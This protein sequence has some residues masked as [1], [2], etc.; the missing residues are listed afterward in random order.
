MS[1][2]TITG[3]EGLIGKKITNFF[4][5]DHSINKLDFKL[6]HDLSDET[7]VQNWFKKNKSNYLINCFA[8]N[9]HVFEDRKA[10]TLF[11]FPLSA[12]TDYMKINVISLFSVCREF[13]RNNKKGSIVNF[14]STYGIVSPRPD[15]YGGSHKDVAY[16]VSKAS[17]INLTKYLAIH[18][19][20]NIRVNC[21][22][23]SGIQANQNSD[24]IKKYSEL[25]PLKRM[26]KSNELNGILDFLCSKKSSY[27]TG[28]TFVIDGGYT[29]W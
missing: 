24:F 5:K 4:S 1:K 9:D 28:S 2:I 27:V 12:F 19:A 6:G 21:I 13:A 20:P 14:S 18:L 17:V 15:L 10:H 11:N 29:S 8:I 26:M 3:S 25:I 7:F 16:S 23:P 22:A